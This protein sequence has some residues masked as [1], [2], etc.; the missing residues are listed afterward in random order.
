LYSEKSDSWALGMTLYEMLHGE[1]LDS[2]IET[3][4]Y[5]EQ[6]KNGSFGV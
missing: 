6:L 1:T 5:F 3:K 4:T 2:N